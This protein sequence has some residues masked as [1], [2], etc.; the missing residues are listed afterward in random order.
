MLCPYTLKSLTD[1]EFVNDEHVIPDSIGGP[2]AYVVQVDAKTNST[3]G[4]SVDSNF[5]DSPILQMLRHHH[6]V[7]SR[8]GP[9]E[10]RLSGT[11]TEGNHRVEVSIS[12]NRES[13][14]HFT[15]PFQWIKSGKVA[16][17]I[18]GEH[19]QKEIQELQMRMARKGR[20]FEI[21]N[22]THSLTTTMNL[23]AETNLTH[24]KVGL[25]KIAYL[26]A[27]EMLGD[28][29][30]LDPLNP[31]WQ[32]AIRATKLEELETV[33]IGGFF[34]D[35]HGFFDRILPKTL[36]HQH[37]VGILNLK[38][39]GPVVLVRLF[40][41][42]LLSMA[43]VASESSVYEIPPFCGKLVVINARSKSLEHYSEYD[44]LDKQS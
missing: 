11:T 20:K 23:T 43:C 35:E 21:I 7:K 9:A 13:Q 1:L 37:A 3:L 2:R 17:I 10:I 8:T 36:P 29:F 39:E 4:A 28:S 19:W 30:L 15:K 34:S 33:K 27:F 40:G 16:R 32:K 18:T 14:I 44:F 38:R 25:L 22:R 5:V 24:L 12:A 6:G 26:S 41:S 42:I 31:E